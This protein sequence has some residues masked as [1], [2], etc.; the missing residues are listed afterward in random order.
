MVYNMG[1]SKKKPYSGNFP[2]CTKFHFHHNGMCT[3]KFHKCN[4]VRHFA[5]NCRSS[6]NANIANAQRDNRAN[7]KGNGCFKC[8]AP[9]H[10]KRDC[11]KLKNKDGGKVNELGWVYAVGNAEKRWNA[12]KDLDSNV[13]TGMFLLNNRYT[14][15]LFDTG[16]DRSFISTAFSSLIDIVPTSLG[17][18][19][20]VKLADV[21]SC[22]KAQEYMAKECQIFLAQISDKK[23][24]ER[25]EGK[26]LK[27]VPVIRDFPEVFPKDLLGLPPARPV[28]FRIDLIPGA[29]P[30]RVREQDV[31]KTAFT[32][33]YGHYEFEVMP[34]GLTNAP[35]DEKE[36]EKHLKA[37][38]ELL[39]KEKLYAKFSKCECW[40][41][42]DKENQEKDKIG[43]KPNKN[44]KRGEAEKSLKQL[45]LKEEEKPKKTKKE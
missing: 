39:K 18:S 29:A 13:F 2:K 5:R 27:D 36:H 8:G 28:E 20:D 11:P 24:E 4:K 15:I 43:S 44:G 6:G 37:F 40:I 25:S 33:R 16:A 7:P 22:S 32:T 30:L 31:P 38:L 12:S 1:T 19:Y 35:A 17:N 34:F 23:E 45:Q 3:Q 26:Q 10:F 14:S 9:G 42:K 21:I 41:P